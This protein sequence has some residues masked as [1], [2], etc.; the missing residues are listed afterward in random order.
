MIKYAITGRYDVDI[1]CAI[2][3]NM[4][5]IAVR[6]NPADADVL[7]EICG[8]RVSPE[9]ADALQRGQRVIPVLADRQPAPYGLARITPLR[10]IGSVGEIVR[11]IAALPTNGRSSPSERA[12]GLAER[13]RKMGRAH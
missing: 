12:A 1:A 10:A 5:D 8:E 2:A 6:A 7:F 11:Q 9:A 4:P 3:H 13:A